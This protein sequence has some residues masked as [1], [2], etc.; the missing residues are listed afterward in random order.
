VLR[1]EIALDA[2][3]IAGTQPVDSFGN[4]L[5][6]EGVGNRVVF[7]R[8]GRGLLWTDDSSSSSQ[9]LD[10]VTWLDADQTTPLATLPTRSVRAG[11]GGAFAQIVWPDRVLLFGGDFPLR[12]RVVWLNAGS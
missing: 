12:T 1:S 4:V 10:W 8:S 7:S 5:R 6:P 3:L 11:S 2:E 9:L